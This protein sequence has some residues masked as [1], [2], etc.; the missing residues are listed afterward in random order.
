MPDAIEQCEAALA[1]GR[2]LGNR[3]VEG[4]SIGN[5]MMA[6]LLAGD[7]DEVERIGSEALAGLDP[8]RS[9]AEDIHFHLGLL[10]A[11]RGRLEEASSRLA[12]V[13]AWGSGDDVEARQLY[14][15]LDGLIAFGQGDYRR[16]LELLTEAVRRGIQAQGPS[17]EGARLAWFEAVVAALA[18]GRRE[19]AQ[20]MAELLEDRP[21]GMVPPLLRA[22]L[23]HAR[24]LLGMYTGESP[25]RHFRAAMEGLEK[26]GYPYWLARAQT[27]L[28]AWLNDQGRASEA[29]P[30][31]E[32]AG[33]LRM[34]LGVAA[35]PDRRLA[36]ARSGDRLAVP[37]PG[38][39]G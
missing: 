2:Q 9:G 21:T 22:E 20:G 23:E 36:I 7:W 34:D 4:I 33:R 12:R 13:A 31:L 17:S 26:L 32:Q 14:V 37:G 8:D 27:D 39:A 3:A 11:R 6:R 1:T 30:L 16:A 28:G 29:R 19:E 10:A 18:L 24:G 35:G 25:E 5:L 38:R 15:G